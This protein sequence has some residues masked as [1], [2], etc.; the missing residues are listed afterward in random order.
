MGSSCFSRGNSQ[1]ASLI[2][3]FIKENNLEKNVKVEGCLCR[4]MCKKGPIMQINNKIYNQVT[5]E[6]LE[7]LLT[8]GLGLKK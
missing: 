6:S 3:E 1:I 5:P 2:T 8:E 4:G 7:S